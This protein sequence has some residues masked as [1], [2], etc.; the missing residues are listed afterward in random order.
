MN[1]AENFVNYDKQDTVI[2]TAREMQEML[3]NIGSTI[4][5]KLI[6][7]KSVYRFNY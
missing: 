4:D 1:Q 2:I 7:K 3:L 6:P 5:Y